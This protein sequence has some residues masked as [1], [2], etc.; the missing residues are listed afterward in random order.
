MGHAERAPEPEHAHAQ[1]QAQAHALRD[2]GRRHL[3]EQDAE[4]WAALIRPGVRLAMADEE[5]DAAELPTAARL[6]GLPW[7]P[8]GTDWP[9]GPGGVPLAFVAAVECAALPAGSLDLP[10]PAQGALAFFASVP[11]AATGYRWR[12]STTSP[13]KECWA[14]PTTW[15]RPAAAAPSSG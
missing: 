1:A 6:G 5:W 15:C 8:D 12:S 11:P 7:L 3:D 13:P 10:L 2:I 14:A 9:A 4:R